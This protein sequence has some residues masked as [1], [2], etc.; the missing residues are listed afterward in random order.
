[1]KKF[2]YILI[3]LMSG[4][5]LLSAATENSSSQVLNRY[6][7]SRYIFS[8]GGVEFSVY[9]DGEFDFVLP[10]IVNGLNINLNSG[11]VNISYNSGYNYDAY[12]QYDNYGAVIQIGDVPVYYDNW[13]RIIQAGNVYLNYYDNRLVRVGGLSIYYRGNAFAYTRGYVNNYNTN[14]YPGYYGD[15]FYR[16]YFDRCLVYTNPYRR[17]YHPTRYSYSYHRDHYSAGYRAGYA[18]AYHDFDRPTGQIAHNGWREGSYAQTRG[19][20]PGGEVSR[21][22]AA[23]PYTPSRTTSPITRSNNNDR[24]Q[25]IYSP[26]STPA[27]TSP[28]SRRSATAQNAGTTSTNER[29]VQNTA[30]QN[31]QQAPVQR[32][33]RTNQNSRSAVGTRSTPSMMG[34]TERSSQPTQVRQAQQQRTAVPTASPTRASR[35]TG[36][37]TRSRGNN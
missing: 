26:R 28:V 10:Q 35:S 20:R 29:R 13:G 12:V 30:S 6:D 31:A 14:V 1:M 34:R 24:A 25:R 11:P 4:T 22:T 27:Q 19:N 16:P 18:N 8:E 2:I 3:A 9:P 7:G 15:Y 37:T 5:S 17:Y 23:K 36:T 32:E 21:N 33:T